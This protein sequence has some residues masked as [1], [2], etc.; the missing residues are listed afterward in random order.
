MGEDVWHD[1]GDIEELVQESAVLCINVQFN[2]LHYSAVQEIAL[3]SSAI[4]LG[5]MQ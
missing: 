4:L 5:T 1:T 3:Q 2:N